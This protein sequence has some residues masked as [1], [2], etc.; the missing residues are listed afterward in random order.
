MAEDQFLF[1]QIW[2][3]SSGKILKT[4]ALH[5]AILGLQYH[6]EEYMLAASCGDGTICFWDLESFAEVGTSIRLSAGN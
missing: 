1:Q 5:N 6:P 2:D 3:V 4:L